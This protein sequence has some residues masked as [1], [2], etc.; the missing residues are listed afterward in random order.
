MGE[1]LYA[2]Y[3]KNLLSKATLTGFLKKSL[4]EDNFNIA[5]YEMMEIIESLPAPFRSKK[6]KL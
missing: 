5:Y 1:R 2:A 4:M 3:R 6:E